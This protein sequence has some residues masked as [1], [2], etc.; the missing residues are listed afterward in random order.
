METPSQ[1]QLLK[2]LI[3]E[4]HAAKG[5]GT[6][7]QIPGGYNCGTSHVTFPG[8]GI[9]VNIGGYRGMPAPNIKAIDGA[10]LIPSLSPEEE[11]TVFEIAL[12]IQ[13]QALQFVCSL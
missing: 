12:A 1:E 4:W 7:V 5:N 13:E 3:T 11:R 10:K 6:S 2:T 9:K 8:L